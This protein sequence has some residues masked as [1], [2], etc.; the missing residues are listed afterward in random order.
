MRLLGVAY[1]T[2]RILCA[3]KWYERYH[4]PHPLLSTEWPSRFFNLL[5]RNQFSTPI[6]NQSRALQYLRDVMMTLLQCQVQWCPAH[7]ALGVQIRTI[8]EQ[9]LDNL[10]VT[11]KRSQV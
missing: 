3:S 7:L 1:C 5:L 9:D 2:D 6:S 4:K 10:K 8:L 11:I